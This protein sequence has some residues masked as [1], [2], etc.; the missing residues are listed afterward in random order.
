MRCEELAGMIPG[1]LDGT[2]GGEDAWRVRRHT[3][4]CARCR[5]DLDEIAA[6]L[7]LPCWPPAEPLPERLEADLPAV[8]PSWRQTAGC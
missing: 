8:P 5:A 2:L 3:A 6:V 7:Q 1:L 4:V